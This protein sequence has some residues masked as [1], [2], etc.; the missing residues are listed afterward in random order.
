M[1]VELPPIKGFLPSTLLDWEGRLAATLFLGGCNFRCGYCH[2]PELVINTGEVGDIP[3]QRV[4]ARLRG[5][6]AW[7]DGVCITGGEPTLDARLPTLCECMAELGLQVKLD[8]NGTQ[9]DMLEAL[10]TKGLVHSVAMDVKA[11]LEAT[12]YDRIAGVAVD[13]ASLQRAVQL[14]QTSGLEYEFRTT[15][16]EDFLPL[17]EISHLAGHLRGA[18]KWVVQRFLPDHALHEHYRAMSRASDEYLEATR[19]I[20]ADCVEQC[21]VRG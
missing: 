21:V 10:F 6:G 2:N 9:P 8:T 19:K 1:P 17:A 16:G 3:W 15:A 4:E 18:R 11:P 12:I 7:L 14:I 20:G 13:V 5:F